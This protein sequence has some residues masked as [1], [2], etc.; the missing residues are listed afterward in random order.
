MKPIG[1]GIAFMLGIIFGFLESNFHSR[2]VAELVRS[3]M[4][5]LNCAHYEHTAATPQ[6]LLVALLLLLA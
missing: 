3:D 4:G 5:Y 2:F 1:V 6:L